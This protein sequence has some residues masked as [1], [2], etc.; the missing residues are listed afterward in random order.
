[1]AFCEQPCIAMEF[2]GIHPRR[3]DFLRSISHLIGFMPEVGLAARDD[4]HLPQ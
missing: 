2:M 3:T 1:V 4:I